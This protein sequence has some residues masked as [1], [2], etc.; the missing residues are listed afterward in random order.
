[1]KNQLKNPYPLIMPAPAAVIAVASPES[2]DN[3]ITL[4]WCGVACSEPPQISIGISTTNRHSYHI[5]RENPEFT[6]NIPGED[7]L[8]AAD[9]CGTTHGNCVDKW[10]KAGLTRAESAKISVPH[11]EEFPISLECRVT[12]RVELGSH[13]LFVGEILVTTLQ[14]SAVEGVRFDPS[15]IR[16]LAYLPKVGGYFGLDLSESRG[17]YGCSSGGE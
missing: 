7:N 1:M 17:D 2:G 10:E 11:I 14:E 15:A 3:L 4:A 9:I 6:V 13:D 5:I 12:E 16:P 8:R